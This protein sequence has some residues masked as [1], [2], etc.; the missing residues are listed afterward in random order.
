MPI[1]ELANFEQLGFAMDMVQVDSC[2]T[3]GVCPHCT[4]PKKQLPVIATNPVQGEAVSFMLAQ[5]R[6][7]VL[8]GE[9]FNAKVAC[10][11]D[12]PPPPPPPPR[13]AFLEATC[14]P[15]QRGFSEGFGQSRVNL[16]HSC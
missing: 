15:S 16:C 4:R 8:L 1:P 14:L 10:L 6:G 11:D 9:D 12:I 13:E 3:R 5:Q 2:V 7:Y